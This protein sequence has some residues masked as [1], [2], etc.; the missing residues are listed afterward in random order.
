MISFNQLS[1]LKRGTR[2]GRSTIN[3]MIRWKM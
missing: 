1:S 2:K 3:F